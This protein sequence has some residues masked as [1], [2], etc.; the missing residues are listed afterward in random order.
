MTKFEEDV[1]SRL[2]RIEVKIDNDFR[3]LHGHGGQPGLIDKHETLD[4]RVQ[5]IETTYKT[6]GAVLGVFVG[7]STIISAGAALIAFFIKTNP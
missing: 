1:I 5:V 7:I 6:W 3:E 2:S 4:N